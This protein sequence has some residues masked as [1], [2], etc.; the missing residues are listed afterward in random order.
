LAAFFG[1]LLFVAYRFS[2]EAL[3]DGWPFGLAVVAWLA[4]WC[5]VDFL[6]VIGGDILLALVMV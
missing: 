4:L 3:T 1:M 5:K 6:W 2:R